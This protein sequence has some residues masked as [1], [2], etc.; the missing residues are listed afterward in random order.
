MAFSSKNGTKKAE[1]ASV[2]IV[3]CVYVM[4][5]FYEIPKNENGDA[6]V[7]AQS[8]SYSPSQISAFVLQVM[9]QAAD[10]GRRTTTSFPRHQTRM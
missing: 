10:G 6:W 2:V 8:Q 1:L 7:E 5:K 9:K 4:E 3:G